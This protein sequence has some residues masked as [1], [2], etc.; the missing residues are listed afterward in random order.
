MKVFV[1]V[2]LLQNFFAC[3]IC[4]ACYTS[5]G[6]PSYKGLQRTLNIKKCIPLKPKTNKFLFFSGKSSHLHV[7]SNL[8]IRNILIRN[9]LVLRNHFLWPIANLLHKFKGHL[10]SRN[11]FRVTKKFLITKY[12]CILFMAL[13]GIANQKWCRDAN[14]DLWL[15]SRQEC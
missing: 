11:N 4:N 6:D 12:D 14:R 5:K 15:G 13:K 2:T 8:A 9:K 3:R 7:Q 1:N 10:A